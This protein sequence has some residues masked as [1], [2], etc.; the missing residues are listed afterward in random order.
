MQTTTTTAPAPAVA[1]THDY[2][3]PMRVWH[4]ANAVLVS[5]QLLTILFLKVIVSARA[6]IPDMQREVAEKGGQLTE[7]QGRAIAHVISDRIWSWHIWM[8]LTLAAFWLFWTL[9]Q[10]LD[11]AGRRFG[12]RLLAAGRRYRLA[13]PA[14]RPDARS[15]LGAK[16]TYAVFYLTI[17]VMVLT[18]LALT[19]ADDVA[20]LGSI[21]HSVGEVHNVAM[22]VII[23]FVA[24]HVV[25]V[26]WSEITK[27]RGLISRMVSGERSS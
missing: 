13:P 18:G 7:Q 14:E 21:E 15:E 23:G 5:G 1:T 26:V 19:W 10:V 16:L 22:Y 2:S 6:A 24:L 4:W 9:L 12:A 17:T 11:P 8:G 20:W 3:A 25:G 27:D